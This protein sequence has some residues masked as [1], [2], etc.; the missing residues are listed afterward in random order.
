MAK[1][2]LVEDEKMLAEMYRLRFEREGFE[3]IEASTAEEGVVLAKKEKPDLILLDILLPRASGIEALK[4]LKEDPETKDIPIIIF[5][6]YDTP[7]VREKVKEYGVK[8]IL[9]SNVTT[10]ELIKIVKEELE[11]LKK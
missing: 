8:Y 11:S 5:S 6:N 7:K 1:I 2:L 10:E 4:T 9:K 3:M